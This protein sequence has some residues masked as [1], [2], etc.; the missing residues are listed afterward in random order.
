MYLGRWTSIE[1][2]EILARV[3]KRDKRGRFGSGGGGSSIETAAQGTNPNFGSTTDGPTYRDAARA[4]KK[5]DPTMGPPPSG[6]FEENCTNC[7]Q[8]FEMRMR[9]HD[10]RAAPLTVLD[11]YGYAAGRT[12]REFDDQLASS[13]SLPGGRPHGRGLA[14]QPWKSFKDVDA[15]VKDWPEGGRGVI[16]TGKH[17]FNVVKTGGRAEYV[18]SQFGTSQIVTKQYKKKFAASGGEEAK[19]VRLDDLEPTDAISDSVGA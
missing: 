2:V 10:V 12:P 15:E 6:A 11:K 9:G 17:V 4:G 3:Y 18:E 7:V 19:V 14:S 1:D 13:W 16:W 5:W 8:A